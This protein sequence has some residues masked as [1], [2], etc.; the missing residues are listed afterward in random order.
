MGCPHGLGCSS[1]GRF[2]VAGSAGAR[3]FN[4]P[5]AKRMGRRVGDRMGT[6][7]PGP[8]GH[9]CLQQCP[10]VVAAALLRH[11]K[12]ST[13]KTTGKLAGAV[14]VWQSPAGRLIQDELWLF[15][16]SGRGE[17]EISLQVSVTVVLSPPLAP[18][19]LLLRAERGF[20]SIFSQ[21]PFLS[22]VF[23]SSRHIP[24]GPSI[25]PSCPG[26]GGALLPDFSSCSKSAWSGP[27]EGKD[28]EIWDNHSSLR[29][30]V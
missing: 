29:E 4:E 14:F 8:L 6:M 11:L 2:G 7:P 26:F 16:G 10:A 30:L 9:S 24:V 21:F 17:E 18:L 15:W 12:Q 5:A 13:Q 23:D 25:I 20:G 19:K 3:S 1:W 28:T 27:G 22:V